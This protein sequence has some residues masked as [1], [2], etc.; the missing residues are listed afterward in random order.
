M[1]PKKE[2]QQLSI[3]RSGGTPVGVVWAAVSDLGLAAVKLGGSKQEFLNELVLGGR[4]IGTAYQDKAKTAVSQITEYLVGQR[5]RFD[6]AID[7]SNMTPF[8]TMALKEVSRIPYGQTLSYGQVAA[9]IDRSGAARAVGRANATN[10]L[11]LVIPCHRVVASDG[12]LRGYGA[13]EGLKTKRWLLE[14]E[15]RVAGES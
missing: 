6:L 10:P 15:R 7:W 5:T 9:Q 14:M 3:A 11:P 12:S 8:Q 13:G 2:K 1:Q 4:R